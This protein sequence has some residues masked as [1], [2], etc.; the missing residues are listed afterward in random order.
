MAVNRSFSARPAPALIKADCS[1]R[2]VAL[3]QRYM[4]RTNTRRALLMQFK[5]KMHIWVIFCYIFQVYFIVLYIK[6]ELL[7]PTMLSLYVILYVLIFFTF[8]LYSFTT[9]IMVKQCLL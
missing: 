5:P 1:R 4:G 9:N 2:K 7:V 8:L 6:R 3:Q